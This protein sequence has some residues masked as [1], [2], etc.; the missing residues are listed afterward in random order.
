VKLCNSLNSVCT[1]RSLLGIF[2]RRSDS[3]TS[4]IEASAFF[5]VRSSLR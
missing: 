5:A 1:S 2:T 4:S 3:T